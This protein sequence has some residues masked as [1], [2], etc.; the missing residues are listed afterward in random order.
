M[1][2]TP[3]T[4]HEAL[5]NAFE[6]LD[7]GATYKSALED[8]LV[9][10]PEGEADALMLL[11]KES[12][13]AWTLFL[14]GT[15][16]DAL[17]LGDPISGTV[18]ALVACGFR[19]VVASEDI[20]RLRFAEARNAA[21]ARGATHAIG[22]DGLNLPFQKN[23][24]DLV[25]VES[26]IGA[27]PGGWKR[28]IERLRRVARDE[29]V[30]CVDNR[31]A[32]KRSAG[33]RGQFEVP[34]LGRFL[35]LAAFPEADEHTLR[36]YRR[37][38]S[39][40]ARIDAFALYPH[41]REFSHVVAL[42]RPFPRLTI[43]PRERVNRLKWIAK[44]AGLFPL[45][46]PS[47]A[48]VAGSK[49]SSTRL[50]ALLAALAERLGEPAPR[51]DIV[52]ATRSN[53]AVVHTAPRDPK[54]VRGTGKW[55]LH[56]PLSPQKRSMQS[57]HF[58][59]L[60]H[61]RAEYPDFP[62][63]KPLFEGQ[64]TGLWITAE[65]RLGGLTAPH[66]T[67]DLPATRRIYRDVV[68]HLV[69][70]VAERDVLLDEE[71]FERIV[72]ERFDVVT[73]HARRPETLRALKRMR[74]EVREMLLGTRVP[75]VLYHGDLRSKHVQVETDGTVVGFLDWG[76]AERAFLPYV[77]LLHL[78]AHQRKHEEGGSSE[79]AWK[80]L[81]DRSRAAPHE[82]EAIE[83]YCERLGV[84]ETVRAAVERMFPVL[85]A[86]MAELHWDYSRPLW[87]HR[88]FGI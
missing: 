17:F 11:H 24:F 64:L 72:G 67:G 15:G 73:A 8:L 43:G 74:D 46:T 36:G 4:E 87:L 63:P 13:G 14:H 16:G 85:V 50:D 27:R 9:A 23:S 53:T 86:G 29:L 31:F 66:L 6:A 49:T 78:L 22:A 25:V 71:R 77:D 47:F 40:F 76:T 75:L 26:D 19:V 44:R 80:V 62:V 61:I 55:T 70:L 7:A 68:E 81:A 88:Q 30:L 79:R 5:R 12:R 37:R 82:L 38:L 57:K 39:T 3:L 84:P 42:D 58:A 54:A 21:M 60:Q 45:L 18:P 83:S 10:L 69:R 2:P 35:R 33:R 20:G 51:A 28:A 59:F 41:A 1:T 56:V 32:Y 65:R 52:V 34:S 48:L